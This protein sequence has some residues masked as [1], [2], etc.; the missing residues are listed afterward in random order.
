MSVFL[1]VA[2]IHDSGNFSNFCSAS[3][4]LGALRPFQWITLDSAAVY[5]PSS[6]RG[7]MGLSEIEN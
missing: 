1:L 7:T 4:I 5:H 6:S 3:S 2:L